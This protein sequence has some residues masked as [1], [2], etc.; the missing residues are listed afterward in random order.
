[1][2]ISV[3]EHVADRLRFVSG[4]LIAESVMQ[5]DIVCGA[6]ALY[7]SFLLSGWDRLLFSCM[8]Q[9]EYMTERKEM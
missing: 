1:M 5:E 4:L 3:G 9:V 7:Q 6:A 2:V 8:V